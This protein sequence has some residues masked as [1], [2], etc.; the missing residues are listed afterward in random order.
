MGYRRTGDQDGRYRVCDHGRPGH[1]FVSGCSVV[2]RPCGSGAAIRW[3]RFLAFHAVV[4]MMAVQA[5]DVSARA[6]QAIHT[7]PDHI[8]NFAA[9]PTIRSAAAGEW[10]S[11]STWT[12]ARVPGPAD[13]VSVTHTVLYD[14]TSG[15]A[16]VVGIGDGGALRFAIAVPTRLTVG[17]VLV[18]PGG[19][20]EIGTPASPIAPSVVAEIIIR[21]KALDAAADPDQFGTGLLAIDGA[22]IM[23]GAAKTPTFVRTA[24]EPRARDVTVTLSGPVSGWQAGDRIFLPDTRQVPSDDRFNPRYP[25]HIEERRIKH[26]SADSRTLTLDT[27][28]DFNHRGARD[29]D[30]KPTVLDNGIRLLPHVGNLTRN[31]RIRSE[32]P[33]GT[34]G[35]TLY[36]RRADVRIRYVQFQDLGRTRATPLDL[37]TNRIG[38]YPVHVHHLIGPASPKNT[39]YQFVL[40]GNAVVDSLKWPIAVHASHFGLI[41]Q[42]VVFG[43][44]QLTGAGIAT[45]DGSETENL[46]EENFVANIRGDINPRQSG[47][48]TA[49]GST[50]GSA[51]EC[52]WA[53]GFNNRFVNN[54]AASCRNWTQQIVSGPGFK[55]I[56]HAGQ[57]TARNPKFRGAD[58][59]N[60]AET[61]EVVPQR[62]PLLEFRGNEV[63]GLAADGLTIWHLGT[64]GYGSIGKAAESVIQDFRVWHTHEGAVWNYPVNGL[65]IDGLVYRIDPAAQIVWW[66][67]AVTSGDYRTVDLTVRNANI[68]AGSVV[69]GMI[70]PLGTITLEHNDAVTYEHAFQFETPATPGTRADRPASGVSIVLRGNTIRAWPGRPL[71]TILM[72][73]DLERWTNNQPG[74]KYQVLVYDY[75]GARGDNFQLFFPVQ[76]KTTDFYGGGATCSAAAPR[77][78]EIRALVCPLPPTG[79]ESRPGRGRSETI[80]PRRNPS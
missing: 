31:I 1:A 17:T 18:L 56:A 7:G 72:K 70:D 62:Q 50:P 10:S 49:P 79:V 77:E 3:L 6:P 22:V 11:P 20:L 80:A 5:F 76:A 9:R 23:H 59:T 40:E 48:D 58:M 25:L 36:T 66:P 73:H 37:A 32:N 60:A 47:P 75:Q 51:A 52:F 29:A 74:D 14:T 12:P 26:I 65:T 57:I 42:N 46:F 4:I 45:E 71:R 43:G 24:V 27:P 55:F 78:P 13:I 67:P 30:G 68:H 8:P 63:Y 44:S 28:L 2:S 15:V 21:D 19:R 61:T 33:A 41:K 54:V 39:G 69:A 35:H 38:R 64:D 16:D 53:A 34:R